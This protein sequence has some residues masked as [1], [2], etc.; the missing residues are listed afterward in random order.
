MKRGERNEKNNQIIAFCNIWHHII[1][2]H[3]FFIWKKQHS[4][5]PNISSPSKK[6]T[7]IKTISK[8]L[9]KI[10]INNAIYRPNELRNSNKYLL[11]TNHKFYLNLSNNIY[12]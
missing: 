9:L 12:L 1:L 3:I 8:K 2:Y 6:T 7:K 11:K 10:W 4:L 5:S